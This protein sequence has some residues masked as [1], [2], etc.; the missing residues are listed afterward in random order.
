MSLLF[1]KTLP[2]LSE[3]FYN[4]S[5]IYVLCTV[6]DVKRYSTNRVFVNSNYYNLYEKI[7]KSWRTMFVV[8]WPQSAWMMA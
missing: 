8:M 1:Y 6:L 7:T 4:Y 5:S 3:G 2:I